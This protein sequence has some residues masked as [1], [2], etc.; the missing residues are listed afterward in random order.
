M[1]KKKNSLEHRILLWLQEHF[2]R[3][4]LTIPMQIATF[5]G[6]GGILWITACMLMLWKPSMRKASLTALLA[7]LLSVVINNL[8]LK[9]IVG[10]ARPY[11]HVENLKLLIRKPRDFSFPSGHTS[12]S[13]AAATVFL[14][15]LPWWIGIPS[16]LFAVLIA[17][18]R[19]YLG[20]HYPSDVICGA[21]LGIIFGIV[22][23]GSVSLLIRFAWLPEN[24]LYWLAPSQNQSA[25]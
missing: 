1:T 21:I 18:S 7:L 25:L 3:K 17:F 8:I 2:R 16:L 12:S 5:L 11:V 14:A 22:A 6:N 19:L 20:A 23:V 15:M 24:M 9:N 13:F 4:W 10:R